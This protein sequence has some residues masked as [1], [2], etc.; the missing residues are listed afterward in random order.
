MTCFFSLSSTEVYAAESRIH[1]L[2]KDIFRNTTSVSSEKRKAVRILP[3]RGTL[4]HRSEAEL[5]VRTLIR[6]QRR[7]A[8]SIKIS[9]RL[10]ILWVAARLDQQLARC[11]DREIGELMVVVQER[12]GIFEVEMAL[13]HH[14]R[15]RL[16]RSAM[17]GVRDELL[18]QGRGGN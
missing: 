12:F 7:L 15:K 1:Y 3:F 6:E 18:D 10:R 11:S 5:A 4:E 8:N 2:Y 9:E 13:C 17:T 14:A 16:L